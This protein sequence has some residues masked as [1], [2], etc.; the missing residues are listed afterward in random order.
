M[1]DLVCPL[2]NGQKCAESKC[3]FWGEETF[4]RMGHNKLQMGCAVMGF[5]VKNIRSVGGSGRY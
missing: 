2:M 5:L 1:G 3:M 4:D